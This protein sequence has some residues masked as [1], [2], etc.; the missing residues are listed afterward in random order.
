MNSKLKLFIIIEG[1]LTLALFF[2]IFHNHNLLM[3]LIIGILFTVYGANGRRKRGHT[4]KFFLIVGLIL[5]ACIMMSNIFVW[6][7]LAVALLFVGVFADKIKEPASKTKVFWNE[8]DI[9]IIDATEASGHH[10]TI[11]KCQWFGNQTFGDSAYEWDDININV[12]AGDTI[13]DLGNTIIPANAG[14]VVI[15]KGLGRTRVLVPSGVGVHLEHT[16]LAGNVTFEDKKHELKNEAV[17]IYS[18][19]YDDAARKLRI[20]T[21]TFVGDIEVLYV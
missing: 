1:L 20:L 14:V 21:T 19:N 13:V 8:P 3:M 9:H 4:R 16:A 18:E 2:S 6:L 10:P 5:F 12:I 7:M 17:S 11:E 15:R